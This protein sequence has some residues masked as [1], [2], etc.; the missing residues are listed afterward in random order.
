MTGVLQNGA[1]ASAGIVQGDQI[2]KV[3][4]T[5]TPNATALHN[6]LAAK[7]PGD[8]VKITYVDQSGHTHTATVTLASGPAD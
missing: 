3:G 7:N 6:A 1:A 5:S 2:T 4:S 8:R